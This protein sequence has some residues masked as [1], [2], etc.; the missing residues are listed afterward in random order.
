MPPFF[1]DGPQ[2]SN[3]YEADSLLQSYLRRVLPEEM[4]R[5]IEPDLQRLGERAVT[6]ILDMGRDAE[7]NQ[8]VLTNYDAWG[9]RVDEVRVSR[10]WKLL[11]R[12]AGEEGLVAIGYRREFGALSRVYQF[13]KLHLYTPS[14]AIFTCPLA[15]CDG[16]ARVLELHGTPELRETV[17]TRLTAYDPDLFWTS[18]QWMTER[19]GGSDVSNSET[20][21]RFE[22]G[23]FRLYGD[24]FFTSS[25][26]S[27]VALTLARVENNGSTTPG[28]R[29]L[30][31]FLCHA[32][33]PE[34][35]WN[36]LHVNRLKD[37]LGTRA[38]PTAELSLLGTTGA[39]L[40]EPG[41]GVKL[42]TTLLNTTRIY[43]SMAAVSLMRRGLALARDFAHRRR[44][45]GKPL[46]QHPLHLETLATLE[47]EY[48]GAFHLTFHTVQLLG[49]VECGTA[50]PEEAALLRLLT[51]LAKLTTGKQSVAINSEVVEAFGGTGYMED[52]GI[53][54]LLR[55]SQTLPIWEGTTNILSLDTLR[56]MQKDECL[57]P[58]LADVEQRLAGITHP[59][60]R[61]SAAR[62]TAA[63]GELELRLAAAL[64]G[65]GAELECGARYL[66]YSLARIYTAS[67]LLEH[68]QWSLLHEQSRRSAAIA[69]RWAHGELV[70]LPLKP[71]SCAEELAC[72]ALGIEGA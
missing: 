54:V 16:N 41:Q 33:S 72:I 17:F 9:K 44:A 39:L 46:S 38:L 70:P 45:F 60:L 30:S 26:T 48:H 18:G 37:K 67:L 7:A 59:E 61:E 12:T 27:E 25:V 32:Y 13:A 43:N 21:A 24:K 66:A 36:R 11:Q 52:S 55:D 71:H 56:A 15:M 42:I 2:L 22:D 65:G 53:P 68:G 8:P 69:R 28:N 34:G 20:V 29:G 1:Q 10:G 64:R 63:V 40:G 14:S 51:P 19:P 23:Q 62:V 6:D 47:T 35:G 58:Y 4:L 57:E 3:Q 49:K 5:Q 31:M 50:T